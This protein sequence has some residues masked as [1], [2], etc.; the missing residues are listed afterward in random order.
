MKINDKK[1]ENSIKEYELIREDFEGKM[2]NR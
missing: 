1:K 2:Q